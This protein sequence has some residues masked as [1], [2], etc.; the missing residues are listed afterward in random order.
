MRRSLKPLPE[1]LRFDEI[2]RAVE[3]SNGSGKGYK[4]NLNTIIREADERMVKKIKAVV[5]RVA[6]KV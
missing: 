6:D 5:D 2:Q 1:M 4:F 3:S